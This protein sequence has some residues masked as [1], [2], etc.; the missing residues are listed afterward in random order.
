MAWCR[1]RTVSP[2]PAAPH[3]QELV[4]LV[5]EALLPPPRA[6]QPPRLS[7]SS[8]SIRS[9]CSAPVPR[10]EASWEAPPW[11][12]NPGAWGEAAPPLCP[13]SPRGAESRLPPPH[14]APCPGQWHRTGHHRRP[15][16]PGSH[17]APPAPRPALMNT[18][19]TR[20]G[21]A[22]G[23]ANWLRSPKSRWGAPAR[24]PRQGLGRAGERDGVLPAQGLPKKDPGGAAPLSHP[25]PCAHPALRSQF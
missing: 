19:L 6:L 3:L 9:S 25:P 1:S 11:P 5:Q 14:P 2:A 10:G 7:S 18:G 16:S 4:V 22:Q 8:S 23:A 24:A 17:N 21:V 20:P 12:Y 13:P 15:R